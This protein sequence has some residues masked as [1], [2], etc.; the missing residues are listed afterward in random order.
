MGYQ[1]AIADVKERVTA[2]LCLALLATPFLH[3]GVSAVVDK[4]C[5][6]RDIM[7]AVVCET[8]QKAREGFANIIRRMVGIPEPNPMLPDDWMQR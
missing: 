5:G 1:A 2:G 4:V 3:C 8:N 6:D 7:P